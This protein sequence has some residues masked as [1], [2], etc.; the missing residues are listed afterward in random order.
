[1]SH[2]PLPYA[3]VWLE[4]GRPGWE[5]ALG[6]Y[7]RGG[8][9]GGARGLLR[10]EGDEGGP[11]SQLQS[12]GYQGLL[13]GVSSLLT[14]ARQQA[15]AVHTLLVQELTRTRLALE[16]RGKTDQGGES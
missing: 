16:T 2:D 7:G 11:V 5:V 4:A 9:V 15:Q 14:Q 8:V 10:A 13:E 3:R 6:V 1:M 12:S